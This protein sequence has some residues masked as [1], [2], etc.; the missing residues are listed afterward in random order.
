MTRET[1]HMFLHPGKV[2]VTNEP[3]TIT[4]VLG[5]CVSVILWDKFQRV[6]GMNHFIL[7]RD[8]HGENSCRY[9]EVAILR[10][11]RMMRE[12]GSR[13]GT[14]GAHIAG[15]A[16]PVESLRKLKSIGDQNVFIAKEILN[17]HRIPILKENTGGA[18]GYRVR[19]NTLNGEIVVRGMSRVRVNDWFDENGN[20]IQA[21][22][23]GRYPFGRRQ[24]TRQCEEELIQ[25]W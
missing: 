3:M 19:L 17:H 12:Y 21:A 20:S 14:I 15:G 25:P 11:L 10:L 23:G 9:G 22:G 6:G 5:S 24:E 1:G 2:Y 7:P 8:L 13:R 4:T 18:I 16:S